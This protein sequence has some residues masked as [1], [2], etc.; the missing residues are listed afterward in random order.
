[1]SPRFKQ[2][3]S[4][5]VCVQEHHVKVTDQSILRVCVETSN[6]C[7]NVI[8]FSPASPAVHRSI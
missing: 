4:E 3:C 8:I 6:D 7:E 1:M 5:S 2:K